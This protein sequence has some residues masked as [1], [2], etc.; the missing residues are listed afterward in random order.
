MSH[1]LDEVLRQSVRGLVDAQAGLDRCAQD[2][3][4]WDREG[5]PPVA[6]A[7]TTH[8][9]VLTAPVRALTLPRADGAAVSTSLAPPYGRRTRPCG[10]DAVVALTLRLHAHP[11]TP[12]DAENHE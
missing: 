4:R 7:Y 2:V 10:R 3:D 8:R 5:L 11:Q 6:L 1:T 9:I 12:P